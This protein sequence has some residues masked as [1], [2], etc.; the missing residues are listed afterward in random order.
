MVAVTT[1]LQWFSFFS[2]AT[3][4]KPFLP[5]VKDVLVYV[6]MSGALLYLVTIVLAFGLADKE[7]EQYLTQ[8][9][10]AA[11]PDGMST[12]GNAVLVP[13]SYEA[14]VSASVTV[15]VVA[16]LAVLLCCSFVLQVAWDGMVTCV[17]PMVALTVNTVKPKCWDTAE[18]YRGKVPPP[19]EAAT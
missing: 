13:F 18:D 11:V 10:R 4:Q 14:F 15:S 6:C 12:K 17:A 8:T 3:L 7:M 16:A 1:L 19:P 2:L 9:A 5:V